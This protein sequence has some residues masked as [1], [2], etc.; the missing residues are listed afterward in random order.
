MSP[1]GAETAYSWAVLVGLVEAGKGRT[2]QDVGGAPRES[3][4][5]RERMC[6]RREIDRQNKDD[7]KYKREEASDGGNADGDEG[8]GGENESC[9]LRRSGLFNCGMAM[10]SVLSLVESGL[11]K[12]PLSLLLPCLLVS[13]VS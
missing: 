12:P 2:M 5:E 7:K 8:E 9:V 4:R 1:D 10:I 13:F 11:H 6:A 3:E